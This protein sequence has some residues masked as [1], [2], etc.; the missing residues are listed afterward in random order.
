MLGNPLTRDC[1]LAENARCVLRPKIMGR[2][3]RVM[4]TKGQ[5]NHFLLKFIYISSCYIYV[6]LYSHTNSYIYAPVIK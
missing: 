1:K 5:Q 6:K 2:E 3:T 4:S